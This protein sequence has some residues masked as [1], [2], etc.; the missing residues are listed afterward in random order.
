MILTLRKGFIYW[1]YFRNIEREEK[2]DNK[3]NE[4]IAMLAINDGSELV[5][6]YRQPSKYT[7]VI[8]VFNSSIVFFYTA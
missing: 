1:R 6:S 4:S 5:L 2:K 8:T 3:I 7:F